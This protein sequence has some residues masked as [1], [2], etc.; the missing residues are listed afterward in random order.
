MKVYKDYLLVGNNY[1]RTGT[2][3]KSHR[4]F[5]VAYSVF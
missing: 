5:C 3:H 4:L 2:S 1:A